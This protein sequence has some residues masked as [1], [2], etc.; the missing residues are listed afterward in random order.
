MSRISTILNSVRNLAIQYYKETG[1]PLGVTG[2]MAEFEASTILGL[3][4][5]SA[6][7]E[8]YDALRQVGTP[9]R[10]Q[11][12]GRRLLE[13][14]K[15]GQRLG[16]IRIEKDWDS[17]MLVLLDESYRAVEIHEALKPA[18]IAALTKPGSRARN[19]R[20]ALAVSKFKS[21]GT[22]IWPREKKLAHRDAAHA[23]TGIR[24]LGLNFLRD[25]LAAHGSLRSQLGLMPEQVFSQ[26][27]NG[28]ILVSKFHSPQ[29]CWWHDISASKMATSNWDRFIFLCKKQSGEGFWIL[30]VPQKWLRKNKSKTSYSNR[31]YRL[32]LSMSHGAFVD[33]R[34]ESKLNFTRWVRNA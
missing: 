31:I 25:Q 27:F 15:P 3:Q 10:I 34:G 24:R 5:C 22:C 20:G 13:S 19:E 2:E 1:K 33:K 21:I 14:S 23:G 32:H 7:Q 26:P 6:R 29:G 30:S 11:I 16:R 9:R 8:G 17:V 28:R 18:I 4:L 12:K